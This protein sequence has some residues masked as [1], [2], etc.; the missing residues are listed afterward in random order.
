MPQLEILICTLNEGIRRAAKVLLPPHPQVRYLISWQQ[1][2]GYE[3]V[4]PQELAKREDLHVAELPNSRGLSANRNHALLQASGD[5]LLLADDDNQYTIDQLLALIRA[6]QQHP[7]ADILTFQIENEKGKPL[8]NYPQHPFTY[9]KTPKGYY[10]SSCEI[11]LRRG[12]TY[13]LF[14]ERFGLGAP[15]LGCG[16]EEVFL[17]QAHQMGTTIHYLPLVVGQTQGETT[18]KGFVTDARIRRAKGAVLYVLHGYWGALLRCLKF[19]LLLKH[20]QKILFFKDMYDGIRY[21][22]QRQ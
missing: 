9:A 2:A 11:A 12:K 20:P 14:D 19:A 10:Y 22:S 5:F 17:H 7:E 15:F 21:L 6:F 1:T 18:G 8:K 16:E 4:M 13:P 3:G